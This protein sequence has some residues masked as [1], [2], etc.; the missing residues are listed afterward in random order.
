MQQKHENQRKVL[1]FNSDLA[2]KFKVIIALHFTILLKKT[3]SS[4]FIPNN[5]WIIV[6]RNKSTKSQCTNISSS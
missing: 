4:V 2:T 5:N 6:N 3:I 1:A